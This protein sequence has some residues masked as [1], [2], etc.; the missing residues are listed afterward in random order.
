MGEAKNKE[1]RQAQARAKRYK[2]LKA[3][4]AFFMVVTIIPMA[5]AVARAAYTGEL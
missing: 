5:L 2:L 1:Y 3:V 4:L